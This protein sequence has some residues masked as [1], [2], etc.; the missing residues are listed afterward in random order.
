MS[1]ALEDLNV[2]ALKDLGRVQKVSGHN[3]MT[4]DELLEALEGPVDAELAKWLGKS[5]QD[6]Y[7]AA[8]AHGIEDRKDKQK[9]ELLEALAKTG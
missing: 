5:R 7:Q 1:V 8:G 4:R 6:I 9:W 2:D 3:D